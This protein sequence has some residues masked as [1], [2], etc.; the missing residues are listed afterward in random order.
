MPT[1]VRVLPVRRPTPR[2]G[3]T[4]SMDIGHA[5]ACGWENEREQ[6]CVVPVQ[7]RPQSDSDRS[8]TIQ[9]GAHFVRCHKG[10]SMRRAGIRRKCPAFVPRSEFHTFSLKGRHGGGQ[11]LC[12]P[13]PRLRALAYR[14][15]PRGLGAEPNSTGL[16][17][18]C[19]GQLAPA[20]S[21]A[22]AA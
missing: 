15:A 6:A 22:C 17:F 16:Y 5:Q 18:S 20:C 13:R 19:H 7:A 9:F 11:I 4:H 12:P 3:H 2:V 21:A 10:L 14:S 8:S 1:S